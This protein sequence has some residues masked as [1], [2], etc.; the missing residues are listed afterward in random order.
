M[1]KQYV[2]A[3]LAVGMSLFHLYAGGFTVLSSMVQRSTHLMF[4]LGLIYLLYTPSGKEA[5]DQFSWLGAGLAL[6]GIAVN[7]Y[8]AVYEEDIAYR[9]GN[10]HSLD[11]WVGGVIILLVLE[12][13]RRLLGWVVPSIAVVFLLYGF[14]GNVIPGLWG[15]KGYDFERVITQL[16]LFT[17]G[18]YGLPLGVCASFIVLFILFGAFLKECGGGQFFID[19]ASSLFGAVRGGPAKVAIVAS[20]LFGTISGSA[21]ANVVGTGAFTIPLMKSI[22][23]RPHFAGAVEAV[24]STGGQFMPP[25][26]GAAAFVMADFLEIPYLRVCLAAAIPAVLYYLAIF[27]MVDLEAAKTGLQGVPRQKLKPIGQVMQRSWHLLLPPLVLLYFLAVI[28]SSAIKAAFNS[29]V[30]ILAVSMLRKATRMGPRKL[31]HALQDGAKGSLQVAAACA[32]AGIIVGITNITGLGMK[33]STILINLSGGSL[34]LLLFITCIVCLI[35][36]MGIPTTPIYIILA[37]LVA[38]ALVKMGVNAQA[39]HLFII[40]FACLC[41]ITPPVALAAY[42]GA[43]IAGADMNKTGFTA[44]K[45]GLAG[46]IVPFVFAYNPAMVFQGPLLETTSIAITAAV[47]VGGLAVGIQGYLFRELNLF[48]RLILIGAA[49]ALIKPGWITDLIGV[50]LIGTVVLTEWPHRKS[51]VSGMAYSEFSSPAKGGQEK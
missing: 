23:Y 39:S 16:S 5:G 27:I 41:A 14:F 11:L 40:Y 33:F 7:I 47:G 31:F 22:G 13:A 48:K 43:G 17:D 25:V 26:M 20:S 4:V 24:A 2:I 10:V 28:Q 49:L 35:L 46:F 30:A 44:V 38:P 9:M 51:A 37:I 12:A 1:R 18:I 21:V 50:F 42:A 8:I 19:L 34:P 3:G 15:H 29:I 32:C 36:G 45:L 6:L